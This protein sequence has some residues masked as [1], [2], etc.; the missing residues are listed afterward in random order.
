MPGGGESEREREA[1]P[2]GAK[3]NAVAED[4]G[5][6]SAGGGGAGPGDAAAS[7][8]ARASSSGPALAADAPPAAAP[9]PASAAPAPDGAALAPLPDA[10]RRPA[11]APPPDALAPGPAA[12]PSGASAPVRAPAAAPSRRPRPRPRYAPAP[13][14]RYPWRLLVALLAVL[15]AALAAIYARGLRAPAIGWA[16]SDADA[17]DPAHVRAGA[18]VNVDPRLSGGRV[19][20]GSVDLRLSP[21]A[22]VEVVSETEVR[23]LAGALEAISVGGKPFAIAAGPGAGAPPPVLLPDRVARAFVRI[24]PAGVELEALEGAIDFGALRL[25]P[26]ERAIARPGAVPEKVPPPAVHERAQ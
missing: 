1:P 13:P 19:V 4:G 2:E 20:L 21:G 22:S 14:P 23:L 7:A 24:S 25:A 15:A 3:G 17:S 5:G 26:G 11:G 12:P 16:I 10:P 6:A 18:V 8:L 9:A